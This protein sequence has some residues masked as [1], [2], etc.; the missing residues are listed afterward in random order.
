MFDWTFLDYV[1]APG[2]SNPTQES[3]RA[4]VDAAKD[5]GV[6]IPEAAGVDVN[7]PISNNGSNNNSGGSTPNK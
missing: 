4:G 7:A 1:R 5:M 3:V 2:E 6:S